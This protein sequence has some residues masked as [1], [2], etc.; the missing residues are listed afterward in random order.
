VSLASFSSQL[1]LIFLMDGANNPKYVVDKT[2]LKDSYDIKLKWTPGLIGRFVASQNNPADNPETTIFEAIQEQL[3]LKLV[4]AN[5]PV[6][7]VVV[8]NAQ[9]PN[10]N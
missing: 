10:T 7:V 2:G 9:M 8:D 6:S 1:T 5:V 3:G 4:P